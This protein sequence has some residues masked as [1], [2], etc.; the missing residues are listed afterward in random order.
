[1]NEYDSFI[2]SITSNEL[3]A[4][5]NVKLEDYNKISDIIE[6]MG[7][8][9]S[10]LLEV[11]ERGDAKARNSDNYFGLM[12]HCYDYTDKVFDIKFFSKKYEQEIVEDGISVYDWGTIKFSM[13][14]VQNNGL[15]N[16]FLERK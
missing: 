7:Y 8:S 2:I 11:M 16:W 14:S 4:L 12:F 1:M 9:L 3:T 5:T 13:N 10:R 6:P 15:C